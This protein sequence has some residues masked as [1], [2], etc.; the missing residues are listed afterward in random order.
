IAASTTATTL[1]TLDGGNYTDKGIEQTLKAIKA[2]F[3]AARDKHKVAAANIHVVGSSGVP[4]AKNR[5]ALVAAVKKAIDKDLRFIDDKTEVELSILGIVPREHRKDALLLDI[6][7]GNTKGGFLTD[8]KPMVYFA[9]PYGSVVFADRVR[10]DAT[11]N[12]ETFA[13]AAERLRGQLLVPPMKKQ[14]A[15]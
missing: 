15:K 8:G 12:E 7:G 6:G 4:D 9:I 10:K 1:S 13:K 3:K 2:A 14:A 5:P 11:K